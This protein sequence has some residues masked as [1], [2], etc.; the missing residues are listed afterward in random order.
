[1]TSAYVRLLRLLAATSVILGAIVSV[2]AQPVF[3]DWTN[4]SGDN[5]YFNA[6][7]W[8]LPG[9]P[10]VTPGSASALVPGATAQIRM[11]GLSAAYPSDNRILNMAYTGTGNKTVQVWGMQTGLIKLY[12]INLSG[13][14]AGWLNYNIVGRGAT[15][16]YG[17]LNLLQTYAQTGA[18][19]RNT[20]YINLGSY[21]RIIFDNSTSIVGSQVSGLGQAIITMTGNSEMDL[22]NIGTLPYTY[23]GITTTPKNGVENAGLIMAPG[24]SVYLG[25]KTF[26]TFQAG[27]AGGETYVLAGHIYADPLNIQAI[28]KWGTGTTI[29]SGVFDYNGILTMRGGAWYVMGTHNGPI[30]NGSGSGMVV[31]GTGTINYNPPATG[32]AAVAAVNIGTG[33][34]LSPGG[35]GTGG[36]LTINGNVILNG[37]LNA[38]LY[39]PTNFSHLTLNGNLFLGINTQM[40]GVATT[41]ASNTSSLSVGMAD[42]MPRQPGTYRILDVVPNS[43]LPGTTGVIANGLTSGLTTAARPTSTVDTAGAAFRSVSLPISQGLAASYVFGPNYIDIIFTQLP[44]AINPLLS[45]NHLIIADHIDASVLTNKVPLSLLDTMNREPSIIRFRNL[46]DQMSPIS[47]YSWY[48]AAVVQSHALVQTVQDRFD[49]AK[50]RVNGSW[51][52]YTLTSRQE[53]SVAATAIADYSNFDTLSIVAGTDFAVSPLL[54]LGGLVDYSGTHFDLDTWGSTSRSEGFTGA[55]YGQYKSGD[56]RAQLTGYVGAENLTSSRVVSATLLAERANS[57]SKAHRAGASFSTSHTTH[58]SWFE[59]TPNVAF[60][61]FYWFAGA[62]SEKDAGPV[63]LRVKSQS[64]LLY[65]GRAGVRIAR[66]FPV[67]NGFIR[68]FVNVGVQH[69]FNNGDRTIKADLFGSQMSVKS[70]GLEANGLRFEAGIDL[71]ISRRAS[72]QIRY[73]GESGGVVDESMGVRAGLTL[74]F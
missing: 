20:F 49:Q 62:F 47:Y 56:W 11:T 52:T 41:V 18:G 14:A 42:S 29:M 3:Y 8:A 55:L 60:D 24:T 35:I 43:S 13:T 46:L 30:G 74:S 36:N 7:N 40:T 63:A 57:K 31:G 61:S 25:M 70:N 72:L 28:Q 59:V 22:S 21:S 66:S 32:A 12:T 17:D 71:D 33:V 4:A 10:P 39:S 19:L 51:D 37:T 67:K 23:G 58:F 45:N 16:N 64:E 65:A 34:F 53:S 50:P 5:N 2:Q 68:P 38:T 15:A 48:P 9:N 1:M 69:Q 27:Q 73:A 26:S 6:A 54:T 44:F